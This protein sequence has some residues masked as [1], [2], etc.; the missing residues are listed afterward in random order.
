[1]RCPQRICILYPLDSKVLCRLS[2]SG[3]RIIVAFPVAKSKLE[4]LQAPRN[5]II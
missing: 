3:I 5:A 2:S 1:M 4:C